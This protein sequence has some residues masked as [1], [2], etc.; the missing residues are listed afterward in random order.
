LLSAVSL[1]ELTRDFQRNCGEM[2][3]KSFNFNASFSL[4]HGAVNAHK[5]GYY[6]GH[7]HFPNPIM[8]SG[9]S[10]A[11]AGP[12]P[13]SSP[14]SAVQIDGKRNLLLIAGPH[15]VTRNIGNRLAVRPRATPL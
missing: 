10:T 6:C 7:S 15:H 2:R 8:Q 12:P 1:E 4:H 5:T 3:R 9:R 14:H 13:H 11:P